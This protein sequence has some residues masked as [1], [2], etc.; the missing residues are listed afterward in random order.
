MPDAQTAFGLIAAVLL[1]SA[2]ASGLVE[3][4]PISFPMIFLFLGVALGSN[5]LGVLDINARDPTLAIIATGS[6]ALVLFL[7][8][9]RLRIDELGADWRTPALALGPGTLLTIGVISGAAYLL[10]NVSGTRA[11]LLGAILASTDPV[12]VRD[13]TRDKRIPRSVRRALGVEASTNDVVVLPVVLVLIAI[14]TNEAS[15]ALGWLAFVARLLLLGPAAG[16]I[17]GVAGAWLMSSADR[18]W[19][20]RRE[21]Q[22]LYGIGLVLAA[23]FAGDILRGDGFLAAFAAG[24]AI[25]VFNFELCD[26]FLEYGEVTAEMLM[27]LAFVLFGAVLS[28]EL[29]RAPLLATLVFAVIVIGVARPLAMGLALRH[30]NMSGLARAFIAWFGPRG[31]ASLLLALLVVEANAPDSERLLAITGLVVMVSVVTHGA[32][33]TPLAALYARRVRAMTLAEEREGTAT[34]LFQPS[35]STST[36]VPRVTVDELA[37]RLRGNDPPVVLDVRTR[38][39]YAADSTHIPGDVRVLPDQVADWAAGVDRER[40]VIAYCT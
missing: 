13:V 38:S 19:A 33:A 2:L 10:L 29:N 30:A 23:Y 40:S 9:V 18:R 1:L 15:S 17:V 39:Q 24:V 11:L 35:G 8:G 36:N 12:V 21:H 16:I 14:L 26:C 37:A 27:L 5:G 3:R 22:A 34:G 25:T 32:S 4:A 7:D 31:L 28:T 20:I 6:L